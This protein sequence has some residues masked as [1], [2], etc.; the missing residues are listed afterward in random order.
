M[1]GCCRCAS[2]QSA[3]RTHFHVRAHTYYS[4]YTSG[5]E[6]YALVTLKHLNKETIFCCDEIKL[7]P[8]K[9]KHQTLPV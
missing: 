4:K 9:I 5:S 8:T 2:L 1:A 3:S 6:L 7:T